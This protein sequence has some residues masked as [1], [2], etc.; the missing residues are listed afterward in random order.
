MKQIA[1]LGFGVVGSGVAEVLKINANGI[2]TRA[3]ESIRVKAILDIRDFSSHPLAALFTKNFDDILNDQ[4]ISVVV[5]AMGGSH[6]AY[7]FSKAALLAGKS[8]V[9]SNKEVVANF[10]Q[11]LTSIAHQKGVH[12]LFEASVGGGI[13][14]IRP[15]GSCLAANEI[16]SV[17]G[18]VNGTTN[19]ILTE[20]FEK[21]RNFETALADAMEKGYAEKNPSADVDGIDACRKICVL[22]DIIFGQNVTPGEV[23]T[24][25]IRSI[26]ERD[27]QAATKTG[28]AIKLLAR[29][30][31]CPDG[32][33]YTLVCPFFV[34]N[35]NM[36]AG[37][38]GVFNGIMVDGNATDEVLF[39]GKGAGKMPTA[40]A[41]V[42]DVMNITAGRAFTYSWEMPAASVVHNIKE[43]PTAFYVSLS[44][45]NAKEAFKALGGQDVIFEDEAVDFI[46]A[47]MT[48][49]EFDRI[50]ASFDG[51]TVCQKLRVL[52]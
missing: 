16:R 6:P 38:R 32:G 34:K 28:Y 47:V 40:S 15:I 26:R 18:I 30:E 45:V 8:V 35:D 49:A 50:L 27:V 51:L 11:E 1:I 24:E 3:G 13:P 31:K 9:T 46:S 29:A 42:A 48:E 44:G 17:T 39:Y 10:G 21:G 25:G 23:S 12:Y 43:R 4:D 7:D 41:M 52:A 36:L 22:S 20:M 2:A 14:V 5:E 37:I 33:L 19:Y